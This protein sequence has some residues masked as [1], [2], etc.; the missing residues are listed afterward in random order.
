[1]YPTIVN[2]KRNEGPP[3]RHVMILYS[4][5]RERER[6]DKYYVMIFFGDAG[7]AGTLSLDST[8]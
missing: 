4:R 8:S 6:Y 2:G 1:M 7:L 5:E 3:S